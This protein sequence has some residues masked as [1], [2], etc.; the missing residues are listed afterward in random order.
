VV[1][2]DV[3]TVDAV[4]RAAAAAGAL[5]AKRIPVGGAYHSPLMKAAQAKLSGLLRRVPLDPPR[6]PLVSSVTGELVNDV[7]AYRAQL[8]A[9]VTRPVRWYAVAQRLAA[10]GVHE[11]VEVGPGR[12]L[13]GLGRETLRGRRHLTAVE[14]VRRL[15]PASAFAKATTGAREVA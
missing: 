12:V 1:S 14:A 8:V 11:V 10:I 6:I 13:A 7:E 9:Q 3:E 15:R 5:R 2:G 4:L